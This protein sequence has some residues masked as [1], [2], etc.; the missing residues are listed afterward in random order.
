MQPQLRD[1]I[2]CNSTCVYHTSYVCTRDDSIRH[3]RNTM[4]VPDTASYLVPMVGL[5]EA[6]NA[7]PGAP[8][9]TSAH[10]RDPCGGELDAR[11]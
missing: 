8:S 3:G 11:S 10:P 5:G 9:D 6:A 7:S 2:V 1:V 4:Y